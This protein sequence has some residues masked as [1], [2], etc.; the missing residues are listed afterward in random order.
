MNMS[1]CISVHGSDPGRPEV[2]VRSHRTSVRGGCKAYD[3]GV[4]I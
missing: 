4:G 1:V 2:G 3:V